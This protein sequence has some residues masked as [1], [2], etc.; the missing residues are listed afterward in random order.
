MKIC[1]LPLFEVFTFP[2]FGANNYERLQIVVVFT[3]IGDRAVLG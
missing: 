1:T 2:P 3:A